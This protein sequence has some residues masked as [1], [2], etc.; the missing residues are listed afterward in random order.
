V[1][2]IGATAVALV[3]GSLA[4][5]AVDRFRFFGREAISFI[6]ILPIA[7]PGIVT[8]IAINAAVGAFGIGFGLATVIVGHARRAPSRRH[9]PISGPIP[10]RPSDT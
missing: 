1:A 10:G 9:R 3:L 4:A 8:G 5:L 2:G 7:L 6:V